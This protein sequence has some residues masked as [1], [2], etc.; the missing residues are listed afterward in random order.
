MQLVVVA[1]HVDRPSA[2]ADGGGAVDNTARGVGSRPPGRAIQSIDGVKLL[3]VA[4]HV[5]RQLVRTDGG[6]AAMAPPVA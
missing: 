6:G 5:D 4:P 1:P 2:C 3:V